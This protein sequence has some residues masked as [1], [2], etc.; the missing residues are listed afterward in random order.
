MVASRSRLT[1]MLPTSG[2]AATRAVRGLA[3]PVG[4]A[5]LVLAPFAVALLSGHTLVWGVSA[6]LYAPTRSLVV[7]ALRSFRLPL[8]SPYTGTGVPLLAESVHGVLHPVSVLAALVAPGAG[9]D[10]VLLLHLAGAA[11][12]AAALARVLGVSRAGAAAAAIAYGLGGFTVSMTNNLPFLAG[13]A[14]APWVLAGL[15]LAGI[16]ARWG[17]VAAAVSVLVCALSG[18]FQA[19]AVAGVLGLALAFE[20]GGWRGLLRAGAGAAAG[21]LLGA[22]QLWPSWVHLGRSVRA[23]PLSEAERGEWAL[24]VPRLVELVAPGFFWGAAKTAVA[25]VFVA[26][27]GSQAPQPFAASVFIGAPVLLLALVGARASRVGRL[28]G[29][30]LLVL[31]WMAFGGRLGAER[32]LHA[33]PVWEHFRYMEKLAG[34]VTLCAAV[35]AGLGLDRVRART[36]APAV[37]GAAV[38][39]LVAGLVGLGALALAPAASEAALRWAG[40]ATP[41]LVDAAR[42]ARVRLAEGLV[43]AV[44]GLAV[45]AVLLRWMRRHGRRRLAD[46]AILALLFAQS[47]AALPYAWH[48]GDPAAD[49]PARVPPPLAAERPVARIDVP[50]LPRGVPRLEGLDEVDAEL[51][52]LA[53]LLMPAHNLPPRIDVLRVY[54]GFPPLRLEALASAHGRALG[55]LERRL[56]TTHLVVPADLDEEARFV[57]GVLTAGA[58]RVFTDP[59]LGFDVWALPHRPWASF[60]P[61][62]AAAAAPELAAAVSATLD[63]VRAGDDT[64]IVEAG[65][66]PAV[67]PGRVLAT[68]RDVQSLRVEAEA[69]GD[70]LLVVNDAFWPGWRADIDGRATEI[71]AADVLVR[72]V[73]WPAGRHVLDMRY[74]P[75]EVAVGWALSAVGLVV[76]VGLGWRAFLRGGKPSSGNPDPPGSSPQAS[77]P[78]DA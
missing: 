65:A 71:L 46:A 32:L 40:A 4:L 69:D 67:A 77:A 63:R 2:A 13:A 76:L 26:L 43:H 38:G 3:A 17:V 49:A 10:G 60:A 7:E 74:E 51:H 55:L 68:R 41:Y 22:I 37:G 12:G 11:L 61:A 72:A 18:D 23:L 48:L 27:G 57:A 42:L 36:G 58:S 35:L 15:R 34:P 50:V 52:V 30:A 44:A 59:D 56:G 66:A 39:A 33:V 75:P 21:L 70:A 19:L 1:E 64:V 54:S 45:M 73:R 28:L 20:G 14:S 25:P 16:G 9:L 29:V 31:L 8:W 62:A 47:V 24:A 5:C 53:R 6:N 78:A